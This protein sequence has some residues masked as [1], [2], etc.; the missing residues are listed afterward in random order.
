MSELRQIDRTPDGP[1]SRMRAR[2]ISLRGAKAGLLALL[3]GAAANLAHAPFFLWPALVLALWVL[4]WQIGAAA[5]EPRR[6]RAGFWRGWCFGTAYFLGGTYWIGSAFLVDPERHAIY[7]PFAV[8]AMATGLG[9]FWG[10]AGAIAARYW[11]DRG[12]KQAV[13]LGFWLFA[14]EFARGHA[15]GG[16]PWH[17]PGAIWPAGGA[18]S[19][20][21][22][23]V[24]LY[25]LSAL[26]LLVFLVPAGLADGRNDGFGR[27]IAFAIGAVALLVGGGIAG[28]NRLKPADIDES[29]RIALGE[30]GVSQRDK[31]RPDNRSNVISQYLRLLEAPNAADAQIIVWPEG[32]L[33]TL[34]LEDPVAIDGIAER[35]GARTLIVGAT[36]R[37]VDANGDGIAFN[38][39]AVLRNSDSGLRLDH[40]Y[41][42]HRLVP[43]SEIVP[44][45]GLFK[46]IG[47][48]GFAAIAGGFTPGP[49]PRSLQL[50]NGV[51]IAPLICYEALFPGLTPRGPDRPDWIVNISNDS[52]FGV[53]TGPP[54]H[55]NQARYRAI[56]EGLPMIRSASG[57]LSAIIDPYG[58]VTQAMPN[59]SVVAAAPP[60][61]LPPTIYSRFGRVLLLLLTILIFFYGLPGKTNRALARS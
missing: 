8:A 4:F 54:Q 21:A 23:Y 27:K 55:F 11:P 50:A 18:M 30:T 34:L 19:Q 29:K 24:G 42:K 13:W 9:L 28:A 58:R 16:F 31:W 37:D 15:F 56:E 47:F 60:E 49:R 44:L 38:S 14:A 1:L 32:A 48:E 5:E 51:R 3:A 17:L 10:A 36:R 53:T 39:L 33:P 41:D 25:G 20:V 45:S 7:M 12:P 40:V 46:A 61:S 57:G 26:T 22:A 2:A 35:L 59:P 6:W 52:W 43:F